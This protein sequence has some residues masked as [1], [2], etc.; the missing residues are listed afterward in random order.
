MKEDAAVLSCLQEELSSSAPALFIAADSTRFYGL[1]GHLKRALD[2]MIAALALI[3]TAPLFLLIAFLV[4]RS[5]PGPILFVQERLGKD[6]RLF[7]FYKFRT[8]VHNSD[9]ALHRQFAAMFINGNSAGDERGSKRRRVYKMRQD[10]RVTPIGCWLR[11]TSLDE[12]PQLFNVLKG[13]MS[14]VGPRPPIPYEIEHYQ[15][16]HLERLKATPGMTGLWQ[17]SGRS[18]VPFEEM[19]RLDVHYINNWSLWLDVSILLRTLP[20]VIQGTGGY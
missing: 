8:M 10:P 7:A 20:V 19:V 5:S 18:T 4:K 12:L 11:R 16:A 9:D 15:P 13:E 17:V 2:F 6:G 14:L 3:I 1:Q